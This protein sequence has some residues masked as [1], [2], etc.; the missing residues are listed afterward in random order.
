LNFLFLRLV[1]ALIELSLNAL[2]TEKEV[3]YFTTSME[4]SEEEEKQKELLL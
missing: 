3:L 1:V 2:S 4:L